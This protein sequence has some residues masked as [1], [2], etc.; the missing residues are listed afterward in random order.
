M[1]A[2]IDPMR[3]AGLRQASY[4]IECLSKHQSK[5]QVVLMLGGDEQLFEMWKSFLRHN[6]WMA[7]THE[8]WSI[9]PKGA[10][11]R[12]KISSA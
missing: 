2:M 7:E 6:R 11:W 10:I 12:Q 1:T 5:E 4:V 8:G 9:T 3:L